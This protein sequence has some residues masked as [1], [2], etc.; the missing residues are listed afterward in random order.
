M[1]TAQR[2]MRI[3]VLNDYPMST[4][5]SLIAEGN[6]PARHSWGASLF[7]PLGA[8][9]VVFPFHGAKLT[10]SLR[11]QVAVLLQ[12]HRFDVVYSACQSE[13]WLLSR[14][15][16]LGVFRK[17]I[18]AVIHHPISGRLRGGERFVRGHDRLL[19]LSRLA[20]DHARA[21]WPA[22]QDRMETIDWGVDLDFYDLQPAWDHGFGQGY[23]VSAGKAN[24]DHQLLAECAAQGQHRTVIVCSELTRPHD[25]DAGCVTVVSDRSGHALSYGQ[26][27]SA[28]RDA[29]AIVIPLQDVQ[30]LAGLT[31]LLDAIACGKPVIMTRNAS[32]DI[33]IEALGFGIWINAKDGRSLQQA[34]DQLATDDALVHQ[35]GLK[36]RQFAQTAYR[37]D[38]FAKGVLSHCEAVCRASSR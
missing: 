26:L 1:V 33:D 16:T 5:L 32:V 35:M 37:Y 25:T 9:T 17:P 38:T 22:L 2:K 13:T 30:G 15:R 14:L 36:A 8:Q 6:Y 11:T 19:F 24:R 21:K 29:R 34:M 28:Y 20:C 27:T 3:A 7:A 10:A 31:S 4:A 23:F 12:Q 18:V